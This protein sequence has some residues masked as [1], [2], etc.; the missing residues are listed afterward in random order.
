MNQYES[1]EKKNDHNV[2]A[3]QENVLRNGYIFYKI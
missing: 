3:G 1:K 2:L